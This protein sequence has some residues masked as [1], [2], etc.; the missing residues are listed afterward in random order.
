MYKE[1]AAREQF[2]THAPK[3]GKGGGGGGD[4]GGGKG[5]GKGKGKGKGG[6][7]KLRAGKGRHERGPC[8][9][10]RGS[11]T[12]FAPRSQRENRARDL[13]APNVT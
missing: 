13:K 11:S 7:G 12:V 4:E 9:P 1:K 8:A 10:V 6:K 3:P 5:G 2:G